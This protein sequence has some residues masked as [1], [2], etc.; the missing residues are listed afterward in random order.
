MSLRIGSCKP[1]A[2]RVLNNNTPRYTIT[3]AVLSFTHVLNHPMSSVAC[4]HLPGE[5]ELA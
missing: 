3:P 2:R 5:T 4:L 1:C